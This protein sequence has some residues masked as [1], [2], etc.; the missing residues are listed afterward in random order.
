[1]MMMMMIMVS[2]K[3]CII[4]QTVYVGMDSNELDKEANMEESLKPGTAYKIT[5]YVN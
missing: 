5:N 1:M 4:K 3:F 2:P